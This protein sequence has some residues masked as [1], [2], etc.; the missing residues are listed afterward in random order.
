MYS[1]KSSVSDSI[2]QGP[3]P[4]KK[5]KL[6]MEVVISREGSA[7]T[8]PYCQFLRLAGQT[9]QKSTIGVR[10]EKLLAITWLLLATKKS[11]ATMTTTKNLARFSTVPP[12]GKRRNI[13]VEVVNSHEH[14]VVRLAVQKSKLPDCNTD[15]TKTQKTKEH[16]FTL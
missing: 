11:K 3:Q 2:P 16:R 15:K 10:S 14:S 9:R 6:E 12:Q 4:R 1:V 5:K 7:P 13:E 8:V